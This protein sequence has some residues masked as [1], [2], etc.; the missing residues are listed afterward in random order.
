MQSR[1]GKTYTLRG[2]FEKE[3]G[4]VIKAV[5][6]SLAHTVNCKNLTV[7][8]S[9]Y[10]ADNE[11][12]IDLLR[13]KKEYTTVQN[14][15]K[16]PIINVKDVFGYLDQSSSM[17]KLCKLKAGH[18]IILLTLNSKERT[19]SQI[20]FIELAN[21]SKQLKETFASLS[22]TL[23]K[24]AL[25][26]SFTPKDTLQASLTTSMKAGTQV[27]FVCCV[28]PGKE[29]L[30]RSVEA[31]NYA[32]R[33]R[34][35]ILSGNSS[36]LFAEQELAPIAIRNSNRHVEKESASIKFPRSCDKLSTLHKSSTGRYNNFNERQELAK[37]STSEFPLDDLFNHTQGGV[38]DL[39][40]SRS[41]RDNELVATESSRD[42]FGPDFLHSSRAELSALTEHACSTLSKVDCEFNEALCECRQEA[43]KFKD[44]LRRSEGRAR[45]VARVFKSL[46]K[47][48][49]QAKVMQQFDSVYEE[50]KGIYEGHILTLEKQMRG[51]KESLE[52]FR[53]AFREKELELS[54]CI[55][56]MEKIIRHKDKLLQNTLNKVRESEKS[57]GSSLFSGAR[58]MRNELVNSKEI[59]RLN[60]ELKE[61][62][63]ENLKNDALIRDMNK[64]IIELT[65]RLEQALQRGATHE[66][67]FDN[68]GMRN[69]SACLNL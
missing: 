49:G 32:T 66:V 15:V 3:D 9:V 40:G 17:K 44:K 69:V 61:R 56:E 63:K 67:T 29:E 35:S 47:G 31:L 54:G 53:G 39:A 2:K 19:L 65:R 42:R 4:W 12:I 18:T 30:E 14:L 33:M 25:G 34:I 7:A 11:G 1:A 62:K 45:E 46:L 60:L 37:E 20:Q 38:R 5:Q 50:T 59:E 22:S 13:G 27:L 51:M 58:D 64:E 55:L 41:Y 21:N 43:G 23:V 36:E 8:L 10:Y 48:S 24:H 26:Q 6:D 28:G 57:I 52:S 16:H 68:G